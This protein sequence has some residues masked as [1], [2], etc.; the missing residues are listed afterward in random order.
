MNKILQTRELPNC[1]I[2]D[3]KINTDE[4]AGLWIF[5]GSSVIVVIIIWIIKKKW[6][7]NIKHLSPYYEYYSEKTE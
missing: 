1:N 3:S 7:L 4:L 5:V 2:E 6:K